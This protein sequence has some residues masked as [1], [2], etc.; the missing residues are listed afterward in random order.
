MIAYLPNLLD[1]TSEILDVL[2]N[3]IRYSID[4]GGARK[5]SS[6]L[7]NK[8]DMVDNAIDAASRTFVMNSL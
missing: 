7:Q 8:F 3:Q 4:L 5:L 1:P 6:E 2:N